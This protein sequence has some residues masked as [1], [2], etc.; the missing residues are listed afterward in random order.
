[1]AVAAMRPLSVKTLVRVAVHRSGRSAPSRAGLGY[2]FELTGASRRA[3]CAMCFGRAT[4]AT[5]DNNFLELMEYRIA[6]AVS[7]AA[8]QAQCAEASTEKWK[9]RRCGRN[10]QISAPRQSFLVCRAHGVS[11]VHRNGAIFGKCDE[12]QVQSRGMPCYQRIRRY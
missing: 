10:D 11:A 12:L 2:D 9:R 6:R 7:G 3:R 5:A 4:D 8:E 1:M